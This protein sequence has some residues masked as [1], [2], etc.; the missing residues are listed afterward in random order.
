M[1]NV[2]VVYPASGITQVSLIP[3]AGFT[4]A[5]RNV[6]EPLCEDQWTVWHVPCSAVL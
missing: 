4:K 5:I 3:T 1:L 6:V 2:V